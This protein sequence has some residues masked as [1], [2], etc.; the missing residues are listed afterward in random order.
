M[1]VLVISVS[2]F[3]RG[4]VPVAQATISLYLDG[5]AV[6]DD[7][8]LVA[9]P[10]GSG[11]TYLEGTRVVDPAATSR[12]AADRAWLASARVPGAQGPYGD[13]VAGALLDLRSLT[14]DQGAL[15]AANSPRWR[16]VWPRDASFGAAALAVAGH[17]D[18]ARRILVHLQDTQAASGT[19]EA[20]YLP[21]GSG[22]T[23]DGRHAQSD[24][25]GW[26]LW[27]IG[28]LLENLPERKRAAV[29]AELRPLV[30]AAREH[31]A[32]QT[33]TRDGLP[34]PSGDY[35]ETS[36]DVLTLGTAAPLLAGLESSVGIYGATGRVRDARR[37]RLDADR[38]RAAVT[39]HFGRDGYP[40]HLRGR[41]SDAAT[42]FLLPPFQPSAL[43]GA[44]TAWAA[45]IAPMMRPAGGL[46]PG[47][48]W[49][50]DGVSWT[51]QT[52]LYALAAASTGDLERAETWLT[53]LDEHRTASGALPE[54]VLADGSPAAVAPLAWTA[55]LVILAVETMEDA[56]RT[57]IDG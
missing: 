12:A 48:S 13:L 35:W 10:A 2:A 16:Y 38:L 55:A 51:P 24:G 31:I 30:D 56:R 19:F 53:W 37:A 39:E 50:A 42:A 5:I 49:R 47:A 27:A 26:A 41:H 20:R 57:P 6:D 22:T 1:V 7:G 46:A 14:N 17:P 4:Q 52:A 25:A 15:I 21:D 54:K 9:I 28:V 8:R 29:A 32:E 43:D 40:R 23:P 11:A 33:A 18:D 34:L 45:S 44:E 36:T 3:A